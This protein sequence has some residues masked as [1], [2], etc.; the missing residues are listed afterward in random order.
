MRSLKQD[1]NLQD[2]AA[3]A[4]LLSRQK[5]CFDLENGLSPIILNHAKN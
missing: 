2:N 1:E 4:C 5:G 3:S